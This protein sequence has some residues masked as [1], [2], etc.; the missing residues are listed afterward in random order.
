MYTALVA[1]DILRDSF[2]RLDRQGF[3]VLLKLDQQEML[4]LSDVA[5]SSLGRGRKAKPK[6][7]ISSKTPRTA[8]FLGV[9]QGRFES[10]LGRIR[11]GWGRV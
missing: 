4:R 10:S 3:V 2:A 9:T 1:L 7:C 8:G 5:L 6:R 11:F